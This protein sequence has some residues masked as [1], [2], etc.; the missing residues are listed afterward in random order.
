MNGNGSNLSEFDDDGDES[1]V[2]I[3]HMLITDPLGRLKHLVEQ[4]IGTKM[5]NFQIFL[6]DSQQLQEDQNLT[7]QCLNSDTGLV[8]INIQILWD[9]KRINIVDVLKPTEEEIAKYYRKIESELTQN[10]EDFSNESSSDQLKSPSK[11]TNS[12][13]TVDYV[14]KNELTK[15]GASEDIQEWTVAHV[16][17]WISWAILKFNLTSVKLD[18]W[19]ITG[20]ELCQLTHKQV[21][22]KVSSEQFE[23]FYTHLEMLR[24]HRYI[25]ILDENEKDENNGSLKRNQKP[26][27][28]IGSDNRNGNNGQIQLWQ[29][30]LEILTDKD[31]V[32]VIEW[33]GTAGE[34]K[35]NDPEYVAQLWGERKNKPAMNYEKLSRALRYYYDGDMISKVQGKRFVYKFVC[36]LKE[37]IGYDAEELSRLVKEASLVKDSV[38]VIK[39]I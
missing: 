6:Q 13:W 14:F 33:V 28:H 5:K 7:E 39:S 34:F 1:D 16:Q 27:M 38:N 17:F 32:S 35:L 15:I 19:K 18:D 2:L 11:L 21:R 10:S 23:T 3:F 4:H 29:F 20:N 8:Q 22:E 25:A 9:K 37:L 30:L 12:K 36:N 26:I 31:Y 24:K